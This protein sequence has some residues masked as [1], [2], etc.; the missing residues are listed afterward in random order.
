ME[1]WLGVEHPYLWINQCG[2][3]LQESQSLGDRG[4]R[5]RSS[6]LSLAT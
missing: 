2:G 4:E 3:M 6:R 5:I 1:M